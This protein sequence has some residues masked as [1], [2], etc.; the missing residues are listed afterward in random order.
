MTEPEAG[1][2][3]ASL[4]RPEAAPVEDERTQVGY[5][6]CWSEAMDQQRRCGPTAVAALAPRSG[7]VLVLI[8]ER[9][10]DGVH[11]G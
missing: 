1:S 3:L 10:A 7:N 5:G 6:I 2:D 9:G 4:K 8:V 11:S